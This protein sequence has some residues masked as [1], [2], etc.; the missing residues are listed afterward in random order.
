MEPRLVPSW[1]KLSDNDFDELLSLATTHVFNFTVPMEVHDPGVCL[2]SDGVTHWPHFDFSAAKALVRRMADAQADA[3][4][5]ADTFFS[6]PCVA[7]STDDIVVVSRGIWL[8]TAAWGGAAISSTHGRARGAS[9]TNA[10]GNA[11]CVE[12]ALCAFT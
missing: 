3:V 2:P 1:S 10:L 6:A 7:A 8:R 12:R 9:T 5:R 11:Y 4:K